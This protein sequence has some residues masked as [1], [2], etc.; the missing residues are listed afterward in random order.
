MIVETSAALAGQA[1]RLFA[2]AAQAAVA[3]R[4][5]FLVALAGGSTPRAMHRV[6]GRDPLRSEI[7]WHATHLYWG[8]E[9]FVP[10]DS[11]ESNY[12]RTRDDLLEHIDIPASHIHPMPVAMDPEAAALRYE[13]DLPEVLDLLFLGLGKDGHMASLF[14]GQDALHE[15]KR[16]VIPV[17][18]GMPRVM[19]LTVTLPTINRARKVVFLVSGGEK[20]AVAQ[21]VLGDPQASLPAACVR[22]INGSLFWILD[23]EAA[24]RLPRGSRA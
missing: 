9:R 21:S 11:P 22:P 16:R 12:G 4:G 3:V 7:P 15:R 19:R 17:E 24:S 20:S 8:D 13:E 5:R 14:P 23:K 6:L 1:A 10:V 18:G 2:E